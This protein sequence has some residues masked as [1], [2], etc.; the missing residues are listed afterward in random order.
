MPT[1]A[2]VHP[3]LVHG[4]V[5]EARPAGHESQLAYGSLVFETGGIPSLLRYRAI[6]DNSYATIL[7]A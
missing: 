6:T 2:D 4:V 3:E 1:R 7:D 5:G